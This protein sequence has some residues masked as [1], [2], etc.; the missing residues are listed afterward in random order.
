M[1]KARSEKEESREKKRP[2]EAT[3]LKKT[4][5]KFSGLQWKKKKTGR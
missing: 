3:S 5:R 4:S 1:K 2:G